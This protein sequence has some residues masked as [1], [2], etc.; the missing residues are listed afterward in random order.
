M[1]KTPKKT[2]INSFIYLKPIEKKIEKIARVPVTNEQIKASQKTPSIKEALQ[3]SI[4]NVVQQ[5]TLTKSLSPLKEAITTPLASQERALVKNATKLQTLSRLKDKIN[6]QIINQAMQNF[7]K[8][9]TGSLMHGTPSYVP[10]SFVEDTEKKVIAS[11]PSQVGNGFSI[12]KGDNGTCTLTEDLSLIGLQGK[13]TSR[14]GCGL[15]K[16]EQ[17]FKSHMKN[18]LKKLGK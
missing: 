4:K 12:T 2:P 13:T 7:A 6:Q 16:D 18:V 5:K 17:N 11:T 14:F 15:S 8:P 9:N 10:H 3:P 1:I